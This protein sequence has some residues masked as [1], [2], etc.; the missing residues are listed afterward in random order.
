VATETTKVLPV[1]V[2]IVP[3]NS[4]PAALFV[5]G[6]SGND[7]VKFA[8]S[9]KTGIAVTLNGVS[10]GTYTT[11][12]PLIVFGQGGSDT[13]SESGLSDPD[14]LIESLSTDNVESDLDDEAL[15]WAGLSAAVEILNA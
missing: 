12:G 14:Y 13:L 1:G 5:G 4:K 6:T 9:G 2:E 11:S 3:F 10:E 8:A 7:T 15:Q